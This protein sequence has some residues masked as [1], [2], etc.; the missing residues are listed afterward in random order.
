MWSIFKF[1]CQTSNQTKCYFVGP[2]NWCFHVCLCSVAWYYWCYLHQIYAWAKKLSGMCIW[3]G[4]SKCLTVCFVN[5]P[6]DQDLLLALNIRRRKGVGRQQHRLLLTHILTEIHLSL[7]PK[8]NI[9]TQ[10][11][12]HISLMNGKF[13]GNQH[14]HTHTT[15]EMNRTHF[16]IQPSTFHAVS[17][18]SECVCVCVCRCT[19]SHLFHLVFYRLLLTLFHL[20]IIKQTISVCNTNSVHSF[21]SS[22]RALV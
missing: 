16:C 15:N 20:L 13:S 6:Q 4:F 14:R 5:E 2:I 10:M 1:C 19:L 18:H 8:H 11:Q 3:C 17:S 22:Y 9:R 12:A 7:L 21:Q